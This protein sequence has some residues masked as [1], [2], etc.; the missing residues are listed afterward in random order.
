MKTPTLS[1]L[2]A[3]DDELDITFMLK[4][5]LGQCGFSI[6]IF[7]DPQVS[8]INFKADYYDLLLLDIK[9]TQMNGFE[10]CQEINNTPSH[11]KGVKV[12]RVHTVPSKVAVGNTFNEPQ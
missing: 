11:V 5:I 9:M 10:L 4:V 6:D 1:R 8:L 3:V 12:L 2:L 7:N